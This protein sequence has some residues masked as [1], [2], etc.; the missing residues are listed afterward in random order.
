MEDKP[1]NW[2]N[3]FRD[4]IEANGLIRW[5]MKSIVK[6]IAFIYTSKIFLLP[7]FMHYEISFKSVPGMYKDQNIFLFYQ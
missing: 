5:L 1:V 2:F 3:G 7:T 6:Y 4:K